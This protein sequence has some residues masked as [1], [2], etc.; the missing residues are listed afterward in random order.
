MLNVRNIIYTLKNG[1]RTVQISFKATLILSLAYRT[2]FLPLVF[3]VLSRTLLCL[4]HSNLLSRSCLALV[5]TFHFGSFLVFVFL[6]CIFLIGLALSSWIALA[7]KVYCTAAC[8]PGHPLHLHLTPRTLISRRG[9]GYCLSGGRGRIV[10]DEIIIVIWK[11][12]RCY[13]Q[14]NALKIYIWSKNWK[15]GINN[16]K[17]MKSVN[18]HFTSS[19]HFTTFF[20]VSPPYKVHPLYFSS[21][22]LL[23]A[24]SKAP[25]YELHLQ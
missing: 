15:M 23:S 24:I 14:Q 18:W 2:S 19:K 21:H 16:N 8:W 12:L 10:R 7:Q 4:C 11:I 13:G 22:W 25:Y 1:V 5:Y 6:L 20:S 3:T 17:K 9:P